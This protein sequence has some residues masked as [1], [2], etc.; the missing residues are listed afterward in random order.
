MNGRLRAPGMWP[1][2]GS[3]GSVSPR[4]RSGARASTSTSARR[5]RLAATPVALTVGVTRRIANVAGAGCAMSVA[6]ARPSAFHF[7]K[8]PSRTATARGRASAASTTGAPRTCRDPGRTRRPACPPQ[9]PAGRTWRRRPPARAAD[10]VRSARSSARTGRGR[11]GRRRRR[12]RG[13]RDTRLRPMRPASGGRAA[14]RR[15]RGP[16]TPA[17]FARSSVLMSVRI[18]WIRFQG[19]SAL[20]SRGCARSGGRAQAGVVL[21]GP[22]RW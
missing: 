2:T 8:P 3:S 7:A 11:G 1:A 22:N 14:R 6:V 4:K 15:R 9:C 12:A 5:A 20:H 16:G 19:L 21:A 10:A 17:R 13:P 18:M